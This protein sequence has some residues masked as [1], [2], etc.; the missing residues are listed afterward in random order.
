MNL[1]PL[2]EILAPLANTP[3]SGS[4]IS[5]RLDDPLYQYILHHY[6]L[7]EVREYT[8]ELRKLHE[9]GIVERDHDF[10]TARVCQ[11]KSEMISAVL[12]YHR[13]ARRGSPAWLRERVRELEAKVV[14][15]GG[16][17]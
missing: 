10:T 7:P 12:R 2:P 15:L 1:N 16:A 3:C 4:L 17:L 5:M 8:K 6:N 13:C 9:S 11:T 14:S